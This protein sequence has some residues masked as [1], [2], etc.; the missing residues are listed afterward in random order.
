M[1][2]LS[3]KFL[4]AM[5]VILLG[6][7]LFETLTPGI[8]YYFDRYST[9]FSEELIFTFFFIS[10]TV[11]G[12]IPPD[13]FI[14]WAKKFASPYTIVALLAFLSYA[15][16]LL[17]YFLG[18]RLLAL[19]KLKNYIHVKFEKQFAMLKSWGGLIIVIAALFPLPFS[20]MCLGAGMLKYSFKSLAILGVF[21]IARFF[22]YAAVLYQVV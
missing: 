5:L 9:A 21:R 13:L 4:G 17:A 18:L 14:V 1:K 7:Y 11:L 19:E 3:V 22:L 15:A 6:L 20:T 16:G 12:L 10:E 2:S 8:A